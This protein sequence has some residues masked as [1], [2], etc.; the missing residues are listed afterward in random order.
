MVAQL[1]RKIVRI[2]TS[3]VDHRFGMAKADDGGAGL[4]VQV[5]CSDEDNG[6]T[7]GANALVVSYDAQR[8][9]YEVTP[10]DDI[11]PVEASPDA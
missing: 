3:R 8:E 6:L 2:D 9:V 7:R 5:R 1:R 4:I 11:L 10:F